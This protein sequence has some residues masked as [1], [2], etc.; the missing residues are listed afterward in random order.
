MKRILLIVAFAITAALP[1]T[2]QAGF[3]FG[4]RL[5]VAAP[6]GDIA[7]DGFGNT[8]TMSDAVGTSVPFQVDI[9]GRFLQNHLQVQGYFGLAYVSLSQD[10]QDACDFA[11]TTCAGAQFTFGAEA[12]YNFLPDHAVQ[13]WAGLALGYEVLG[14]DTPD[15]T[16]TLG[17]LLFTMQGGVDFR[18]GHSPVLLGP[19]LA[20]SFGSYTA[21]SSD[22]FD[23][24]GFQ[25]E[26]HTWISGGVKFS[27][28]F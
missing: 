8:L 11:G 4:A 26:G 13:P 19:Y 23:T 6:G 9:G 21:W 3:V 10:L 27:L 20:L 14:F 15:G 12:Q 24:S 7:S 16:E 2:A 5:G 28:A 22:T 17:G 18:L 1:A 25:T